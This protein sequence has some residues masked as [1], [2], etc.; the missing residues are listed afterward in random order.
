MQRNSLLVHNKREAV[1]KNKVSKGALAGLLQE[2]AKVR[3]AVR[4]L[5]NM[6]DISPSDREE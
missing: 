5:I 4:C 3:Q 1:L 6:N 2:G